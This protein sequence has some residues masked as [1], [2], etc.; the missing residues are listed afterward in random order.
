MA[1]AYRA[2]FASMDALTF[3]I[4]DSIVSFLFI[5]PNFDVLNFVLVL[6]Q[7]YGNW[8]YPLVALIFFPIWITFSSL[9]RIRPR[10]PKLKVD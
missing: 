7:I 8:L 6:A 3:S 2:L 5:Q 9:P 10:A 1:I 4:V